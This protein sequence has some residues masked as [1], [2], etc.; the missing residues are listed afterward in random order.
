MYRWDILHPIIYIPW[1]YHRRPCSSRVVGLIQLKI[2]KDF[3]QV[4]PINGFLKAKSGEIFQVPLEILFDEETESCRL[5]GDFQSDQK[6]VAH[7]F[8]WRNCFWFWESSIQSC[9]EVFS[10]CSSFW[11]LF[12]L[13]ESYLIRKAREMGFG[14]E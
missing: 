5:Q 8:C 13:E 11:L 14:T 10:R 3:T 4:F 12:P 2:P 6:S 1:I 7:S 9:K